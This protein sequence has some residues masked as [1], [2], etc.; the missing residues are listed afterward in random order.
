MLKIVPTVKARL[1]TVDYYTPDTATR[2]FVTR[3]R[4]FFDIKLDLFRENLGYGEGSFS[5]E[6]KGR[7]GS[8]QK[9]PVMPL[10]SQTEAF[11]LRA[12]PLQLLHPFFRQNNSPKFAFSALI[13]SP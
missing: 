10:P 12:S 5:R 13:L 4:E 3:I 11:E 9:E 6:Y 7:K 1:I 8:F 2:D